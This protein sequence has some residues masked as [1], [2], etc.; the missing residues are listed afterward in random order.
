MCSI[1]LFSSYYFPLQ[2]PSQ[3]VY[4]PGTWGVRQTLEVSAGEVVET[5]RET[6]TSQKHIRS[7][8]SF[9][10]RAI[11]VVHPSHHGIKL[12]AGS[13]LQACAQII[14]KPKGLS[15]ATVLT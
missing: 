3:K 10:W 9:G 1:Q 12:L 13:R 11:G 5:S 4:R 2:L 7:N 8:P 15:M 14:T 6:K